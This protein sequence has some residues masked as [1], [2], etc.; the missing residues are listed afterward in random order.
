MRILIDQRRNVLDIRLTENSV[1]RWRE[2]TGTVDI[3]EQGTLIGVEV[4]IPAGEE[5]PSAI[6]YDVANESA[7][8]AI[9]GND[10]GLARS[11]S[12]AVRVGVDVENG[13]A[14]IEIPRRGPGY[15]IGF[16]S[17]NQ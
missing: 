1:A 2:A 17:G 13:V 14:A 3:G 4:A 6:D 16:P 5:L 12:A 11:A 10:S 15:E 8:L 9:T 7:Y